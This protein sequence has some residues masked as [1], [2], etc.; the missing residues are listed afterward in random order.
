MK[1]AN[2]NSK[3]Y[4][5]HDDP[6]YEYL[7]I[8]LKRRPLFK[9]WEFWTITVILFC[10]AAMLSGWF[11]VLEYMPFVLI[12]FFTLFIILPSIIYFHGKTIA[13][14]FKQGIMSDELKVTITTD[15]WAL[16]AFIRALLPGTVFVHAVA[17]LASIPIVYYILNTTFYPTWLTRKIL[18]NYVSLLPL[19]L[20]ISLLYFIILTLSGKHTKLGTR[21]PWW[22]CNSVPKTNPRVFIFWAMC[23]S[24]GI[25]EI[26]YCNMGHY[27]FY[28]REIELLKGVGIYMTLMFV[29]TLLAYT[30]P[31]FGFEWYYRHIGKLPPEE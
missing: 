23:I 17:C 15:Q 30:N 6:I 25:F 18:L 4:P 9:R 22:A 3:T 8:L 7:R 16:E 20:S 1:Q 26:R 12:W 29:W 28:L 10:S 31:H 24:C 27:H 2:G 5:R 11:P 14:Q 21:H 13:K 19:L